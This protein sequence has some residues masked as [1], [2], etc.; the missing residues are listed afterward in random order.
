MITEHKVTHRI[1]T[2]EELQKELEA[3]LKG[4]FE[5]VFINRVPHT[6]NNDGRGIFEMEVRYSTTQAS[7]PQLSF[8]S[9]P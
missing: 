6:H 2:T 4:N 8:I 7:E 3:V 1:A 5:H 9:T